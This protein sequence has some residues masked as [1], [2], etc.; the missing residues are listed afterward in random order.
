MSQAERVV[1]LL[2]THRPDLDNA[3]GG[4]IAFEYLKLRPIR[5]SFF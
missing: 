3:S 4:M 2:P 1:Y 5:R